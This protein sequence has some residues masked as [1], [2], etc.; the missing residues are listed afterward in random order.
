VPPDP[1]SAGCPTQLLLD[2]IGDKWMVLTLGLIRDKPRRFNALR[3]DIQSVTQKM[4][5]QT[6]KQMERD[7]LITRTVKPTM[8][9]AVEYGITPL[10]QTLA[11]VLDGLQLSG[12]AITSPPCSPPGG[13][14]T[15]AWVRTARRR[16]ARM[17]RR[18]PQSR[19]AGHDPPEPCGS[20]NDH[21]SDNISEHSRRRMRLASRESAKRAMIAL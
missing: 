12:H 17:F 3:R 21:I 9:V 18:P 7:G 6:L 15:E 16:N 14:M 8:P 2:R 13:F 1:Y 10:G 5:S 11:A 19:A 20:I 4:L